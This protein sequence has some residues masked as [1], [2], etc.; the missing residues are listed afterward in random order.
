M[1]TKTAKFE[2]NHSR[3]LQNSDERFRLILENMQEGVQII[4]FNWNYI[5]LNKNLE[6]HSGRPNTELLGKNFF[7]V[8]PGIEN[9]KT[10]QILNRC[11]TERI[12]LEVENEFEYPDHSSRWFELNI[13]PV[14]EGIFV[15][16]YDITRRKNIEYNLK[17]SNRLYSTISQINQT[18]IRMKD[19]QELFE[20]VIKIVCEFGEFPLAWIGLY[21]S[22]SG[23]VSVAAVNRP[24]PFNHINIYKP[25]FDG[26]LI[27]SVHKTRKITTAC[28]LHHNP[29]M[30]HW[31]FLSRQLGFNSAACV[32]LFFNDEIIGSLNLYSE[33]SDAFESEKE[34]H[35]IDE[36]GLDISFALDLLDK[37]SKRAA[38][39]RQIQ[40]SEERYRTVADYTYDW[41]YWRDPLG[42]FVFISP[43]C[44][45]MTGY[46]R[47]EFINDPGLMK[48][49]V[50]RDD[51]EIWL[52]H[53][54]NDPEKHAQVEYFD[55][56]IIR[57]DGG[58]RWLSHTCQ[59]VTR[60]DGVY[61]GRR[62]SNRDI[63]E[64][65]QAEEKLIT[66]EK[67][68]QLFVENTPAAIAMFDRQMR[69][70]AVS[71]RFTHDYRIP[72]G[73][74]IIGR[75]HYEVFPEINDEIKEIHRRCLAGE[76]LGAASDPFPRVDGRLDWVRWEVRPW[77]Q[78]PKTIGGIILFS[79]VITDQVSTNIA[80]RK[81]EEQMQALVTSLDDIVFEC[82]YSS[83][84]THVWVWDENRLF[85]PR[86]KILGKTVIET[87]GR[88]E[89]Q[90]FVDAINKVS[91][92]Q[93]PEI[94]EYDMDMPDGKRWYS[95]RIN[96]VF[97]KQKETRS[98]SVLIRNITLRKKA[99]LEREQ[100]EKSLRKIIDLVPHF[101]FA[102]DIAGN[103]ILANQAVAEA[104]G[105]SVENLT[106]KTDANFMDINDEVRH[107]REKDAEV[108]NSGKT[109]VIPEERL[110]DA[111]G[112]TRLLQTVKIPYDYLGQKTGVLG[113]SVDITEQKKAEQQIQLQLNRMRSL[114]E[115]GQ[116]VTSSLNVQISL[117][118]LL[119]EVL[120]QR[121]VDAASFLL[122]NA[123]DQTLEY[124]N[125][126]G[127]RTSLINEVH[128]AL[129]EG[130]AGKVGK[131]R[132][133]LHIPDIHVARLESTTMPLFVEEEVVEY[134]GV[135]LVSK[136]AL[137]GVLEIYNRI[138]RNPDKEW[139]NYL[140][141]LGN[142]AALAIDNAQLF[143]AMQIS[144]QELITAYD[145]TITGWSH[146]L[147]LRDRETEGHSQRV[148]SLT[149]SLA[150]TL[151]ISREEQVHYRRGALLHDIG[152]L[153]IPDSI[154]LKPG[155]LTDEEW[156]IMK[157]HPTYAYQMLS[158]IRYLRNAI[159]IPYCHHEKWDGSGYPR[160]LVGEQIPISARIF[161]VVDVWDALN[162]DRPYRGKWKEKEIYDYLREQKGKH[163][164]PKMVDL[165]LKSIR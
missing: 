83:R 113:V 44:E 27:S 156:E 146:A 64:K 114:N 9:T 107:F 15:R 132:K 133:I 70:L 6:N 47:E 49:I 124:S 11:M 104:F 36:I 88:D 138:P 82:D 105:T 29:S 157:M 84:I 43:S 68:L 57:K 72:E 10:F 94:L 12:P 102:K 85:K 20:N 130:L 7:E 109:L 17:M 165:F 135:P 71:R 119:D 118:F 117:N 164:E 148:T 40:E 100:S 31:D 63:T 30:Q 153:G 4:D 125:G 101:I 159:D 93:L 61:L 77:Y 147:D 111:E 120:A 155:K 50:H 42:H 92:S 3:D 34:I 18:I 56:R 112:K 33:G 90:K 89:G 45:R 32:P 103:Y 136:G 73:E 128:L 160:G 143:E 23:K 74:W 142:Q 62:A 51:R 150:S 1:V 137:K 38:Y 158:P 41:E 162:S 86:N 116:A 81:S 121:D 144:H 5:F 97:D 54:T 151:N 65:K 14:S 78:D 2:L 134:I 58:V 55:Y 35:L 127:F 115:I 79:E 39:E 22:P 152:K 53:D 140:E 131:N 37:E 26:D 139:M 46:T 96:P 161:A 163:F 123:V 48:K 106:G 122:F 75:S 8:W 52:N 67:V 25:P 66:R 19:R 69:Y 149:L 95:A 24:L 21:G 80:L 13:E 87:L 154:L 126:K 98:V 99:E 76:T 59:N 16:S 91:A 60:P 110:T 108:I 145:A 28:N 141:T 129:G